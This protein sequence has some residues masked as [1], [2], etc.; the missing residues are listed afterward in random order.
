M[1]PDR[2][3]VSAQLGSKLQTS[4]S[5]KF[6]LLSSMFFSSYA[7]QDHGLLPGKDSLPGNACESDLLTVRY[8]IQ[9]AVAL[10]KKDLLDRQPSPCEESSAVC[11][12]TKGRWI[13]TLQ[14]RANKGTR[15]LCFCL[16]VGGPVGLSPS[17][18]FLTI[19]APLCGER[20]LLPSILSRN[21]M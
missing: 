19:S 4:S 14:P 1:S 15:R 5:I 16:L 12:S 6:G 18:A 8:F 17:A 9:K 7:S 20:P 2:L 13:G 11:G 10:A 3:Q 21:G